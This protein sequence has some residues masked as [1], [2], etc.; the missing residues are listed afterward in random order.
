MCYRQAH[1]SSGPCVDAWLEVGAGPLASF[2]RGSEPVC[3]TQP[4]LKLTRVRRAEA[5]GAYQQGRLRVRQPPGLVRV[6]RCVRQGLAA[7]LPGLA[8]PRQPPV[9][10]LLYVP[11]CSLHIL[12]A[13]TL[14]VYMKKR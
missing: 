8:I 1:A 7:S 10:L 4:Q 3:T 2:D 9:Y 11:V 14:V 5:L 13:V 6:V 12:R